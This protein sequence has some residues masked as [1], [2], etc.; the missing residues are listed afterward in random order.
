MSTVINEEAEI[1]RPVQHAVE[2]G[3]LTGKYNQDFIENNLLPCIKRNLPE[4]YYYYK[5]ADSGR[6]IWELRGGYHPN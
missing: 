2:F 6:F 4:G 1:S 5:D 3:G